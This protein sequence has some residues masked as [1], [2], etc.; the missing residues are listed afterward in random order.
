MKKFL[1]AMLISALAIGGAAIAHADNPIVQTIYTGDG[2]P[3]VANDT[4]YIYT[5]HDEDTA[6]DWFDM[7]EWHCYSSKDMANW[8][9]LGS[10]LGV[11]TFEWADQ[12]A[13]AAQ[14]IERDGKYYFYAPVLKKEEDGDKR[15]IGV[16]VS[17]KPEGPFVDAIGGPLKDKSGN[18]VENI[19]PTIFVDDNGQAYL[20]VGGGFKLSYLE[21][22]DDMYTAKTDLIDI[23]TSDGMVGPIGY[24]DDFYEAPWLFKRGGKYYMLFS[25]G[26]Y[27]GYPTFSQESVHYATS[28]SPTGPWKYQGKI[29]D[30]QFNDAGG[31][32][33][34]CH[35]GLAEYKGHSYMFYHSGKLPGG[36]SY[37]RSESV[38]EFTF[39]ADGSIPNIPYTK[40]GPAQLQ[41]LNPYNRVEAETMAFSGTLNPDPKG[42]SLRTE[43]RED[44]SVNVCSIDNN[45]YIK[46]KGVNFGND[47]AAAFTAA[48]ACADRKGGT[49]ELYIDSPTGTKIGELPVTYTGGEDKWQ[50]M[51]TNISGA[52]GVKDLYFVFKGETE[53]MF[54]FDYWKFTEKSDEH[55]LIGISAA[56][57]SYK[58]DTAE[59]YN[60][61][62]TSITATAI[63]SD[64]TTAPLANAAFTSDNTSVATVDD[65]GTVTAVDYGTANITV[66][67]GDI[68]E[69]VTIFVKNLDTE[70]TATKIEANAEEL[71]V[72][73]TLTANY[74]VTATFAD[75]HTED[76]TQKAT[77]ACSSDIITADKGV[78]T[79]K[80]TKGEATIT[81]SYTGEVGAA[82]TTEIKVTTFAI[83][84]YERIEAE[85]YNSKQANNE[86]STEEADGGIAVNFIKNDDWLMYGGIDFGEEEKEISFTARASSGTAG[87][88]IEIY[89]DSP[90]GDPIGTAKVKGSG[91]W[92]V[93]SDVSCNVSKVT[94]VH[95]VYLKFKGTS[96]NLMNFNWWKFNDAPID[97]T[98]ISAYERIEAEDHNGSSGGQLGT[99]GA[100]GGTAVNF[101]QNESWL[102]FNNVDFGDSGLA[103]FT[104]R[105]ASDTTGGNIEIYI[106][107]MGGTPIGTAVVSNTG[108]WPTYKDFS[109]N[110][111]E[112]K[113]VHNV[114]LKF[115]GSADFL[116]NL[117]WLQFSKE[118]VDDSNSPKTFKINDCSPKFSGEAYYDGWFDNIGKL[119]KQTNGAVEFTVNVPAAGEYKMQVIKTTWPDSQEGYSHIYTFN[120][121]TA[122]SVTFEY[123]F[124]W[125]YNIPCDF[126]TVTLKKGN[127][128]IKI[129]GN[130]GA[131]NVQGVILTPLSTIGGNEPEE[132]Y[133]FFL[134]DCNP[135]LEGGAGITSWLPAINGIG[136]EDENGER[137]GAV[138]FTI[139]VPKEGYYNMTAG[140]A[141]WSDATYQPYPS[142]SHYYT[143]NDNEPI[144]IYYTHD[145][146]YDGLH[147]S[148]CS[149]P[150]LLKEGKNTIKI[151]AHADNSATDVGYLLLTY[152]R[153]SETPTPP[154]PP[155]TEKKFD[156]EITKA[157]AAGNDIQATVKVSNTTDN[158]VSAQ[159]ITALYDK[160]DVMLSAKLSDVKSFASGSDTDVSSTFV[161][162]SDMQGCYVRVFV[163]DSA[164][165][166]KPIITTPVRA[167]VQ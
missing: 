8:T 154:E 156:A 17:D 3:M 144:I 117:N 68:S 121:D 34:T 135:Q 166:M 150:I 20:Y 51:T 132:T 28:D 107:A 93:Y 80:N 4:V 118:K 37:H 62:T 67:S 147:E 143:I 53:D 1:S 46:V 160:N 102:Q 58:I 134:T 82:V 92:A 57:Q 119:D 2:A 113:G 40:D 152:D 95:A 70:V 129:A 63:Y 25:S 153:P 55:Q 157:Q 167:S 88:D 104:A 15:Y 64:G 6:G 45:D 106:D 75:G 12:D 77:A 126:G 115:T 39:N 114:Y 139:N 101:I 120:G 136:Q 165:G 90:D 112:T 49:I 103:S 148:I 48:V 36:G 128:T 85:S 159:V 42:I 83:S 141:T 56:A 162:P 142:Y 33:F 105:A 137:K 146:K 164:A 100:D 140:I 145:W 10:P 71:S 79:A 84:A 149:E 26:L 155:V 72:P 44:R 47:G 131:I 5:G 73:L 116:F 9:D 123:P 124:A 24:V 127:N 98:T 23:N 76:V 81:L 138:T 35:V 13:W 96:D 89:I 91:D 59:K 110:V 19:D 130:T 109:C 74:T 151:T 97:T 16:A 122:N 61:N 30:T 29:M 111:T 14:C 99:E 133:K 38:E 94:G 163:W 125:E 78:I 66:K 52:I 65:N 11:D 21:L 7:R 18:L 108:G 32:C 27:W 41:N 50:E 22:E 54:K 31:W 60:Q 161:K 87:G 158:S 86:L 69:T 43:I